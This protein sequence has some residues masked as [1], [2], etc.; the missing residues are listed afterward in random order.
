MLYSTPLVLIYLITGSLYLLNAFLQFTIS[1]P[2]CTSCNYKFIIFFYESVCLLLR[3][4]INLQHYVSSYCT[5]QWFNISILFKMLTTVRLVTVCH[6][7]K[8]LCITDSISH[9]V[10]FISMTQLFCKW[11]P[12][13][14]HLPYPFLSS[15]RPL[16]LWQPHVCSPYLWLSFH[17]AL[18][19]HLFC[20]LDSTYKWNI[21]VFVFVWLISPSKIPS[22][23]IS[24]IANGKISI[25][26]Y[27]WVIF[28]CINKYYLEKLYAPLCSSEHYLQ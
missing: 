25:I 2:P 14:L 8:I 3:Y 26:Y 12:V 22:R 19:V 16:P 24:V 13:L 15:P 23:S 4:I 6:H 18:F 28:H 17:F 10:H 1:S 5:T 20:F 21:T 11:K 27:G 7:A 9:P